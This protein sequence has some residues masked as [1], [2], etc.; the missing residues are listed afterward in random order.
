MKSQ[1]LAFVVEMTGK[2][3]DAPLNGQMT[4]MIYK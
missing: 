3:G 4:I 2:N 1:K